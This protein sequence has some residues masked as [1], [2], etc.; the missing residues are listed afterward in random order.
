MGLN[1]ILPFGSAPQNKSVAF[2]QNAGVLTNVQNYGGVVSVSLAPTEVLLLPAGNLLVQAGP[3]SDVQYYDPVSL[4]WRNFSPA[5]SS[6][7]LIASDGTNYRLANLSGCPVG[8]VITT[9]GTTISTTYP[10]TCITPTGYWV[11]GNFTAATGALLPFQTVISADG[12]TWNTYVGG[13]INQTIT[14][15][16]AG[17]GYTLPPIILIQPPA[18]Q[19]QQPFI[20]AT[21]DCTISGGVINAITVRNQGAGYVG[22]PIITVINA[23]GDT[24]GT[25]GVL[26][27]ALTGAGQL[28]AITMVSPGTVRTATPTFSFSAGTVSAPASA[29]ATAI[30]NYS[31]TA[32]GGTA[33]AGVGYTTGYSLVLETGY[34]TATA[35]Y[36]NPAIEKGIITPVQ[37]L[38]FDVNTTVRNT[39]WNIAFGGSGLQLV[40][41]FVGIGAGATT[42]GGI[43]APTVGGVADTSTIYAI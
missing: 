25:G 27:A 19:G 5:D 13:A 29:A 20:P 9:A 36:R 33:A 21:A 38:I 12:S 24:T 30:M 15:T 18:N 16:T 34:S 10:V 7:T 3:Y 28:T 8:A 26:T 41:A 43:T 23:P 40:P 22:V 37:P 39:G 14:I 2:Q 4:L 6:P 1:Q 17:T 42:L 11:G 32:A 31:V 35:T